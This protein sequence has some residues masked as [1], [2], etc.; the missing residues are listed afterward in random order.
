MGLADKVTS[1]PAICYY[2]GIELYMSKE[3]KKSEVIFKDCCERKHAESCFYL[4][5]QYE[6]GEGVK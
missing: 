2:T 6:N 3:Y 1:V 5:I 4:G